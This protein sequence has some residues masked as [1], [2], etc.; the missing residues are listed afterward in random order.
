MEVKN[1]RVVITGAANG[2][3]KEITKQLLNEGAYVCAVDINE[4]SL[5][6]LETEINDHKHLR[7]YAADITD[8]KALAK[9]KK[10]YLEAFEDIDILINNA[11]IVQPF[12]KIN[13]LD[14]ATIHRVMDIN[15]FA[16]VN[17]VRLFYQE[18][19][20]NPESFIVDM[21]SMGGFF[22]FPNQTIYGASKAAVKIFSEGLYAELLNTNTHVMVVFP[23]AIKTNIL[24]NS[25]VELKTTTS[26]NY[27]MT[28]PDEAARQIIEGIKNNSFQLYVG[29]DAKFMHF[30]Y[31][32]NPKKAIKMIND[33]MG[34]IK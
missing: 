25:H 34:N 11:G 17:L 3:G 19:S 30:I 28:E 18:L 6:K 12:A 22:P 16:Q 10:E 9:F 4:E 33:K 29:S 2:I 31:K 32:L 15:F 24:K 20:D 27:K 7:T 23:G 21:S 13:E 5:A 14:E 8:E 1:K 26:G